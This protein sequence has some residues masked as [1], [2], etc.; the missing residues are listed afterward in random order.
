MAKLQTLC[1][2]I[3][4]EG[5]VYRIFHDP[6][7]GG[8]AQPSGGPSAAS[9]MAGGDH[10]S[11]RRRWDGF[12]S[13]SKPRSSS[14]TSTLDDAVNTVVYDGKKGELQFRIGG[15]GGRGGKGAE[16][17]AGKEEQRHGKKWENRVDVIH[18]VTKC[19][20]KLFPPAPHNKRGETPLRKAVR[21]AA[22][23]RERRGRFKVRGMKKYYSDGRALPRPTSPLLEYDSPGR[24]LTVRVVPDAPVAVSTVSLVLS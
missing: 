16:G 21:T 24:P 3:K 15:R 20:N 7:T 23:S 1:D 9:A 10:P 19:L 22:L 5:T 8:S 18:V 12:S 11:V 4:K 17:A 6:K 14:P 2:F 13:N